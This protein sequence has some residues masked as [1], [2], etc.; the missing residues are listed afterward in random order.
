MLS[1]EL[2][3]L[4]KLVADKQAEIDTLDCTMLMLG[5]ACDMEL[6]RPRQVYTR[7]FGYGELKRMILG[8]LKYADTPMTTRQVTDEVNRRKGLSQDYRQHVK[9]ALMRYRVTVQTGKTE[10]GESLWAL[11]GQAA[12]AKDGCASPLRLVR[13][14]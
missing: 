1:R 8:I 5:I 4:E 3:D 11:K 14:Q 12:R 6:A 13:S 10:T 9:R 2:L 7:T